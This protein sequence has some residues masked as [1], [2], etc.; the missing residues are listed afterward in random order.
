[1][2]AVRRTTQEAKAEGR[3]EGEKQWFVL[4]PVGLLRQLLKGRSTWSPP[5][6]VGS[7][8]SK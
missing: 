6:G 8:I 4:S 1:M 3:G 5:E 2:D 7:V